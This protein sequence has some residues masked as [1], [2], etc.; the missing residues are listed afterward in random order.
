MSEQKTINF[1]NGV[2]MDNFEGTVNAIQERPELGEC[3]FHIHNKWIA[4]GMNR[5]YE[6]APRMQR[7]QRAV[8]RYVKYGIDPGSFLQAVLANDLMES[9]GR[10]DLINR[11]IMFDWT[12]W[13]YNARIPHACRGSF[14]AVSQW[15]KIGGL[16]GYERSQKEAAKAEGA[17]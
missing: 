15:I 4:G 11:E 5:S 9:F 6:D 13:L 2:N 8:G 12:C 10:A 7:M 16:E 17:A 14:K 1:A 3:R